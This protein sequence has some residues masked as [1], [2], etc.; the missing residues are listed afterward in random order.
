[1]ATATALLVGSFGLAACG[2]DD[3]SEGAGTTETTTTSETTTGTSPTTTT[4]A[5]E[6]EGPTV[7]RVT[8]VD[9]APEGGIVRT[10]VGKGDRVALVVRSDVADEVHVHGYD[11]SRDVAVGGTVRMAFVARLPGRFE[12]ELEQRGVPIAELTVEP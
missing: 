3:D 4:T 6:P 12:V 10:T 7:V 5:P 11:V 2:G 1:M 8:V 9:G